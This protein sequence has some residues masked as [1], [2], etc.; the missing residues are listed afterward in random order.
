MRHALTTMGCRAVV[1]TALCLRA[2]AALAAPASG[3][4]PCADPAADIEIALIS[5]T[6]PTTG[7]VRIT[8]VVK[9]IGSAA[10]VATGPAHRLQMVLAQQS[11]ADRPDTEPVEPVIAIARLKPGEQFKIDHQVN[12]DA[13]T[14]GSY[15]KFI[16]RIFDT[17]AT[18]PV[19]ATDRDCRR[20]ND[21]K[22]ITA[23]DIDKLFG[24]VPPSGP[25]L[26]LQHYR[27]L[28]GVG[29]NTVAATLSYERSSSVPG[30]I[31]AS[32]APPYSGISEEVP[33]MGKAGTAGIR[34]N[35]PCDRK[36]TSN[37]PPPAVTITYRLWGS[38]G[39]PGASSWVLGSSLEQS[40]PYG[41]LCPARSGSRP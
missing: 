13:R 17:G 29:V 40:I 8:G 39:L 37:P 9:N 36:L 30:E 16:L 21:R 4:E 3:A 19:G 23:A 15:P 38:T 25:R 35:I 12:W 10:W 18:T 6:G 20:D 27:L 26:K 32:V 33:I 14:S 7:R 11:S 41:K 5:K 1:L 28:G 2:E 22:E 24:P 31:T 34:V